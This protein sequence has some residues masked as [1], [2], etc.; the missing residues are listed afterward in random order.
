M[1]ILL[2]YTS[3]LQRT[4]LAA[5]AL[6]ALVGAARAAVKPEDGA[7]VAF[8]RCFRDSWAVSDCGS[9]LASWLMVF[10]VLWLL[11]LSASTAAVA[12]QDCLPR[13]LA[14]TKPAHLALLPHPP[15][16]T[17]ACSGGSGGDHR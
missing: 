15:L 14:C 2:S 1:P 3:L 4:L 5:V 17:L 11:L 9:P 16:A 10:L 8:V 6:L 12:V 7:S 13:H